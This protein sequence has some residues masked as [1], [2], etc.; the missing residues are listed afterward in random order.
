MR[1]LPATMTAIAVIWLVVLFAAPTALSKRRFPVATLFVY[2]AGSH[3]CHQ[4]R[5]RS[6][7]WAGVQMPVCGR[8]LGLYVAGAFGAVAALVNG[9][10]RASSSAVRRALAI[11]AVPM[12]L[13]LALE[14]VG[15]AE[16][17]TVSRFV[18]GLPFGAV[19]GWV[20]IQTLGE[21]QVSREA[22]RLN[23]PL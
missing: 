8:C 15:V 1:L 21:P 20:L 23:G 17:S 16:G 13:S 22:P 19:V 6:F 18:S 9:T 12:I 5:E 14:W 10:R 7:E 3:I 4:R 2:E 11:A